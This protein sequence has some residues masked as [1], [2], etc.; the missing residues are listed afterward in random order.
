[1]IEDNTSNADVDE[2]VFHGNIQLAQQDLDE[3]SPE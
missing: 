1:M 2:E 3:Y